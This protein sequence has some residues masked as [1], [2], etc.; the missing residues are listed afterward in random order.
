MLAFLLSIAQGIKAWDGNG[1][2]ESPYILAN[3]ADWAAF[4]NKVNDGTY[5]DKH[6]KLSETWDN[7][8]EAVTATAAAAPYGRTAYGTRSACHSM[9][10]T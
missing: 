4:A 9:W 6:F 3:A 8:A 5:A 1:T 2:A 10:T 7:S